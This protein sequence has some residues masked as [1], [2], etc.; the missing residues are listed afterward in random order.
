MQAFGGFG[1]GSGNGMNIIEEMAQIS[2]FNLSR[3]C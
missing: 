2:S 1:P 3:A